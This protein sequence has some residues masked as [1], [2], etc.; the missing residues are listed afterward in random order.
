MLGTGLITQKVHI[1]TPYASHNAQEKVTQAGGTLDILY[2]S[3][4]ESNESGEEIDNKPAKQPEKEIR[5][6]T[7]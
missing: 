5:E 4:A 7:D 2:P 6:K 3:S 1:I